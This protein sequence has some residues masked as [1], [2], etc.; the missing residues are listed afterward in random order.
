VI[1]DGDV[2]GL[3]A[4]K[5][6]ASATAAIAANG[7]ALISG[8]ALDVEMEQVS[9]EGMFITHHGRRRMQMTPAVEMS[10]LQNAADGGGTKLG[11]LGDP[12]GGIKLAPQGDHFFGKRRRSSARAAPGTRRTIK[13]TGRTL[14]AEAMY[15]LGGGLRSDVEVGGRQL[16]RH[17]TSYMLYQIL[18]TA[19]G[20]SCIL[21]DVH[22]ISPRK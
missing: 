13:Q 4:G 1:V 10:A 20:K 22:S 12:I 8:H 14:M 2:Q 3:P 9:G 16:Q 15:P 18:S 21:V 19:Q 5:L 17:S 11:G 7:N 6:G